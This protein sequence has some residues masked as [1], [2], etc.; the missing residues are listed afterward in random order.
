LIRWGIPVVAMQFEITDSVAIR[1]AHNFT[2]TWPNV[3]RVDDSVMHARWALRLAKN[4]NLESAGHCQ[5]HCQVNHDHDLL[6]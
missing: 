3:H 2:R 6:Y 5:R 4:D 1:S